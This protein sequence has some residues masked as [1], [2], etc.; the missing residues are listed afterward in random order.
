M[1]NMMTRCIALGGN[2]DAMFCACPACA[3]RECKSSPPTGGDGLCNEC[4]QDL[5]LELQGEETPEAELSFA[6]RRLRWLIQTGETEQ[7][8]EL[9]DT[10][11]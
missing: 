1:N 5:D 9:L 8:L 2:H 11:V 3:C 6:L 10:L 4:S 7:A